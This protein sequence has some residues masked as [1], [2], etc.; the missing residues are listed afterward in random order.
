MLRAPTRHPL[1]TNPRA[2]QYTRRDPD[3]AFEP[4]VPHRHE[5]VRRLDLEAAQR[6]P[7]TQDLVG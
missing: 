1:D 4:G 7:D 3:L 2:L 6:P 5:P